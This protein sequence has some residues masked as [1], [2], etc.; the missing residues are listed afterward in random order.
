MSHLSVFEPDLTI[1]VMMMMSNACTSG[2]RD[3]NNLKSKIIVN[4]IA[5]RQ[6]NHYYY[7]ATQLYR[8][9]YKD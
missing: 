6:R 7:G 1:R 9:I 2:N 3:K 4:E 8:K 5:Q